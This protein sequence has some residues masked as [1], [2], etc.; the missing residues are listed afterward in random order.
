MFGFVYPA[1]F[2]AD[3][4]P[5]ILTKKTFGSAGFS[6]HSQYRIEQNRNRIEMKIIATVMLYNSCYN[7]TYSVHGVLV[8]FVGVV[9]AFRIDWRPSVTNHCGLPRHHP[10][11]CQNNV[12]VTPP[13]SRSVCSSIRISIYRHICNR[14]FF[15]LSSCKYK[16]QN[17]FKNCI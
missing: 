6:Y 11:R 7:F 14:Y 12:N 2:S 15:L 9:R 13:V 1:Y 5:E 17:T 3:Q 16:M 4:S 10:C 8:V